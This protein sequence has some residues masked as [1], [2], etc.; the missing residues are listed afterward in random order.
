[1]NIPHNNPPIGPHR[2]RR[3]S[4][5]AVWR[6]CFAILDRQI[7]LA[8]IFIATMI[9]ADDPYF[10]DSCGECA[11]D[12]TYIHSGLCTIIRSCDI[13]SEQYFVCAIVCAN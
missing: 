3:Y 13:Y 2:D 4:I 7:H 9:A 1:M 6:R 11:T 5:Q 8:S 12:G 10:I